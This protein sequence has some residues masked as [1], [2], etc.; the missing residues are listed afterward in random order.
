[1]AL[2]MELQIKLTAVYVLIKME[3]FTLIPNFTRTMHVH[4]TLCCIS[5]Y[6]CIHN[7]ICQKNFFCQ[8]NILT[9][10]VYTRKV[11]LL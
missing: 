5:I 4:V 7:H 2:K 10:L 11:A 8:K 6:I 9:S 3:L 1:M